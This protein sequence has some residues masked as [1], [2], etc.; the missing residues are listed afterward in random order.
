MTQANFSL[1]IASSW[2]GAPALPGER[3]RLDVVV[4]PLELHVA[5]DAPWHG[6][7][8][9]DRPPGSCPGLW[10]FE[11]VELMLLGDDERYLELEVGPGGHFLVLQLAGVRRVVA[12]RH[13]A[14]VRVEHAD[15]RWRADVRL[16]A[17]W[18][19]EGDLRANGFALY[20]VG[21]GRRYLC[22][23]P[24]GGDRPDFHQLESFVPVGSLTRG[25]SV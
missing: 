22:A 21:V 20:G 13:E 2:C 15:A 8:L 1:D 9:P 10:D 6:D 18:L 4:G 23:F 5:I 7:P 14:D 11:A 25:S 16:P 19:P 3:V 24:T 12:T 17:E